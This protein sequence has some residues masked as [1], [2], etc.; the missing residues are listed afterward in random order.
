MRKYLKNNKGIT[1]VEVIVSMVIFSIIFTSVTAILVAF[2]RNF[3]FINELSETNAML[4]NLTREMLSDIREAQSI[5]ISSSE[6]TIEKKSSEKKSSYYV[7]YDLGTGENNGLLC[8]DEAPVLGRSYYRGRTV[9]T[10]EYFDEDEYIIVRIELSSSKSSKVT[11]RDY[12]VKP[13]A[14][15]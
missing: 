10:L 7:V 4:D 15:D 2:T 8:K 11:G 6:I 5:E 13:L 3:A 14:F 12:A 1:L 9:S